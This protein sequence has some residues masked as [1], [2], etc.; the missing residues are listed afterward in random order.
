METF[1]SSSSQIKF[2]LFFLE[3]VCWDDLLDSSGL[4][5]FPKVGQIVT[6]SVASVSF[7]T[8]FITSN[9]SIRPS[10]T[11]NSAQCTQSSQGKQQKNNSHFTAQKINWNW[12]S[13]EEGTFFLKKRSGGRRGKFKNN[14][15]LSQ[16]PTQQKSQ[17]LAKKK[18][19]RWVTWRVLFGHPQI[20]KRRSRSETRR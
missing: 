4:D 5:G 18:P 13:F 7:F 3:K 2:F 12:R 8:T 1:F 16:H 15:P 10:H 11:H 20:C 14:V 17:P 9:H 6:D 19:V